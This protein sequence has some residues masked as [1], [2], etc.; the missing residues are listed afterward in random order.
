MAKANGAA[1]LSAIAAKYPVREIVLDVSGILESGALGTGELLDIA[2][3]LGIPYDKLG[4][5]MRGDDMQKA[6]IGIAVAWVVQ[7][8]AEPDLTF[9]ASKRIKWVQPE[10]MPVDRPEPVLSG[11]DTKP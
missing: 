9:A 3:E 4:A 10:P 7:R 1:D 6:R 5:A 11:P 8:R 2:D